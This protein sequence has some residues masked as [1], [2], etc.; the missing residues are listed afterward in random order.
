MLLVGWGIEKGMR[1]RERKKKR[2]KYFFGGKGFAE[3][4]TNMVQVVTNIQLIHTLACGMQ[5][6]HTRL[7]QL[8][9]FLLVLMES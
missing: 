4:R 7:N 3:A 8:L 1:E 2:I 9:I 6:K 5:V